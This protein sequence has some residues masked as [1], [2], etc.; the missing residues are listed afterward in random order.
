MC[1]A[2]FFDLKARRKESFWMKDRPK[3]INLFSSFYRRFLPV[4]VLV[5]M[6]PSILFI[7]CN[8]IS[9]IAL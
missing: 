7:L 8:M 6:I 4:N 5:S 1:I 9:A 2:Y 3:D